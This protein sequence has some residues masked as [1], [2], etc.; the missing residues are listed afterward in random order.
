[1]VLL[2]LVTVTAALVA[3]ELK[4][5]SA[6]HAS[7]EAPTR[8]AVRRAPSATPPSAPHATRWGPFNVRRLGLL[9]GQ[10]DQ[11]AVVASGK[12]IV[13]IGGSNGS[14]TLSAVLSGMPGRLRQIARL[15]APVEASAVVL[16]GKSVYVVGGEA[17]SQPTDRI[18]RID[19]GTS[20]VSEVGHFIEPLAEAGVAQVRGSFYFV[21]GWTGKKYGTAILRYSPP[22]TVGVVAR[23]PIGVRSPAVAALGDRLVVAGGLTRSGPSRNVFAVDP[24]TGSVLLLTRLPRPVYQAM[25]VVLHSHMYVLGGR[26]TAGSPLA[27][28]WSIDPSTHRVTPSGHLADRFAGATAVQRGRTTVI[29]GGDR[30]NGSTGPKRAIY[31]LRLR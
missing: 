23:L 6:H 3:R 1:M 15:P 16:V 21:G 31:S 27:S 29:V 5:L 2:A 22:N 19:L 30:G 26:S 11:A 7:R 4:T 10:V 18:L 17:G 28:I 24:R 9:P 13:V 8:L 12:D 25:L 14:G 20:R